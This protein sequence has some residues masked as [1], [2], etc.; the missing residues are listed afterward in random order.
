MK[1]YQAK[2]EA[3]RAA[4]V[5][6]DAFAISVCARQKDWTVR[7]SSVLRRPMSFFEIKGHQGISGAYR[8]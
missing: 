7:P 6:M 5:Y 2:A 3:V 1:D 4:E 8:L